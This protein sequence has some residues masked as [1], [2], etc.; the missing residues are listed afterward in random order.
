MPELND[1]NA[2]V[3]Y[4]KSKSSTDLQATLKID[5]G[6]SK[7]IF[8]DGYEGIVEVNSSEEAECTLVLTEEDMGLIVSGDLNPVAAFMQGRVKVEGDMS[9]AMKLQS[10]FS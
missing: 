3:E 10:F 2:I 7:S 1:F 6:E 5:M 8:I 4:V 9:I